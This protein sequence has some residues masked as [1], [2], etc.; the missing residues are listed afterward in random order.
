MRAAARRPR[1]AA[2]SARMRTL[3]TLAFLLAAFA[4]IAG[5]LVL[6]ALASAPIRVSLAEPLAGS[7]SR[8][9]ILDRNGHLLATDGVFSHPYHPT[10]MGTDTIHHDA[11]HLSCLLLPIIPAE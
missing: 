7:T 6:L 9:D 5:R 2:P 10:Q 4:I 11:A 3:A 1:S 8:P